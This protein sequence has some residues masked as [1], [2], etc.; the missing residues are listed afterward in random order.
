MMCDD[1]YVTD[2]QQQLYFVYYV[3]IDENQSY[4]I[5]RDE[6]DEEYYQETV[7]TRVSNT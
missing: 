7:A 2:E 4:E 3:P 6:D 1:P 5:V